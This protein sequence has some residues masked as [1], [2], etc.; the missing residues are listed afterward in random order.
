MYNPARTV[1][2]VAKTRTLVSETRRYLKASKK[3][4]SRKSPRKVWIEELRRLSTRLD[5]HPLSCHDAE[6]VPSINPSLSSVIVDPIFEIA[7]GN[8]G[9]RVDGGRSWRKTGTKGNLFAARKFLLPFPHPLI[10]SFASRTQ[11]LQYLSASCL[12]SEC[13]L[14]HSFSLHIVATFIQSTARTS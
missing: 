11:A 10:F 1:H 7:S 14:L 5:H 12:L 8:V 13:F 4:W 6:G 2:S 9:P 3:S